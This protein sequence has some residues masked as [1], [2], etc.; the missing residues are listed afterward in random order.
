[1]VAC[2]PP[3]FPPFVPLPRWW[4]TAAR[5]AA[6]RHQGRRLV[7]KCVSF[8]N[9]ET[10]NVEGSDK[11][12]ACPDSGGPRGV[13]MYLVWEENQWARTPQAR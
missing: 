3:P 4:G 9:I 11:R 6:F 13:N 10:I 5:L 1:M 7:V 12:L 2:F 8:F